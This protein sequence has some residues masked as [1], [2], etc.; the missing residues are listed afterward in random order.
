MCCLPPKKFK[1]VFF[2]KKSS[3]SREKSFP[4]KFSLN[5]WKVEIN[6]IL[7]M[8]INFIYV[9]VM[10][11]IYSVKVGEYEKLSDEK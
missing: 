4:V 1:N 6:T 8:C 7:S 11:K 10:E 3:L 5:R 2:F 9:F